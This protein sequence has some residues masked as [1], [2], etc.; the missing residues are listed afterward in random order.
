MAV[1]GG[2]LLVGVPGEDDFGTWGAAYLFAGVGQWDVE[3]IL[4]CH[5]NLLPND[6]GVAAALSADGLTALVG[7]PRDLIDDAVDGSVYVY[8]RS[9]ESTWLQVDKLTADQPDPNPSRNE[10]VGHSVAIHGDTIVVGAYGDTSA[11]VFDRLA[12]GSWLQTARLTPDPYGPY[13]ATPSRYTE[14]FSSSARRAISRRAV[15][16]APPSYSSGLRTVAGCR[17]P[18]CC[19]KWAPYSLS[20]GR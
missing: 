3:T 20:D 2:R 16:Q 9:E 12:D 18:D 17:L 10:Y 4:T 6:F 11:Y 15:T 5:D 1:N 14:T 13:S 8:E 19:P 7:A